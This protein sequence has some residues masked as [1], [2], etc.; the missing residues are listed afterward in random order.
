LRLK[1]TPTTLPNT[2][3][4]TT[5]PTIGAIKLLSEL[6]LLLEEVFPRFEDEL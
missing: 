1:A 6:E 5:A 3:P 2:A 4:P